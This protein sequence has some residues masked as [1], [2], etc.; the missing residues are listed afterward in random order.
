[1]R[2]VSLQVHGCAIC[3]RFDKI[4]TQAPELQSIKVTEPLEL[5]GIDLIGEC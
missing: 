1:M 5:V 4:K 3:Q 2:P